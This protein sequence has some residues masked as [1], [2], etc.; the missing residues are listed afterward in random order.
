MDTTIFHEKDFAT[1]P[2]GDLFD[3]HGWAGTD[4]VLQ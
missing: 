3:F 4:T 1:Y 2:G